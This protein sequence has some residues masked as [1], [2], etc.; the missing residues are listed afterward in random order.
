MSDEENVLDNVEEVSGCYNETKDGEG[1]PK[2][3]TEVE[4]RQEG[5]QSSPLLSFQ[6]GNP[7]QN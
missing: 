2:I 3:I 7:M 6:V 4:V 5:E 1:R